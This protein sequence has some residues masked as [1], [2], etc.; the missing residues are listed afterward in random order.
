M[1]Q[2]WGT[3]L[4]ISGQ[5]S[6]WQSGEDHWR[7]IMLPNNYRI[8]RVEKTL[9][10]FEE[11]IPM[12]NMRVKDL[13]AERQQSARQFAAALINQT[14]AELNRLR[15]EVSQGAEAGTAH[16]NPE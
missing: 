12:L 9:R 5:R 10:R 7:V 8:S 15:E 14:R 2:R 1:R 3:Y 4:V 16:P 13:S 11:D 6:A